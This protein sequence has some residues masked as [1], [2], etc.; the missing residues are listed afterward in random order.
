[1]DRRIGCS[2]RRPALVS[3]RS[4]PSLS[5]VPLLSRGSHLLPRAL[6]RAI[7][8]QI[9]SVVPSQRPPSRQRGDERD[10]VIRP[11]EHSHVRVI[12]ARRVIRPREKLRDRRLEILR[13][14]V[15]VLA[16]APRAVSFEVHAIRGLFRVRVERGSRFQ[17]RGSNPARKNVTDGVYDRF[18]RRR[19]RA[20]HG[21]ETR[22]VLGGIRGGKGFGDE[23]LERGGGQVREGVPRAFFGGEPRGEVHAPEAADGVERERVAEE[24]GERGA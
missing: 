24:L 15:S 14:K 21:H 9:A 13:A 1:M 11:H 2:A 10:G 12:P 23:S 18:H 19:A 8:R 20:L 6:F 3:L 5:R 16:F 17:R 7:I 22:E 4:P